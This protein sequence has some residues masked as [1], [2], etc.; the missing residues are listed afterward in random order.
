VVSSCARKIYKGT[1]PPRFDL[2]RTNTLAAGLD[3]WRRSHMQ[4]RSM[5]VL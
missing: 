3:F 2:V 5:N 1:A 4:N